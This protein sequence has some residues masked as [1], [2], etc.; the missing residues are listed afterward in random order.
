MATSSGHAKLNSAQPLR[1]APQGGAFSREQPQRGCLSALAACGGLSAK[2]TGGRPADAAVA[3]SRP[4]RRGWQNG[5][6]SNFNILAITVSAKILNWSA[7]RVPRQALLLFFPG[8]RGGPV[9]KKGYRAP[10]AARHRKSN[11]YITGGGSPGTH[12]ARCGQ[13]AGIP[14]RL[15]SLL[16]STE[17]FIDRTKRS[18][19]IWR[20]K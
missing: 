1:E 17:K 10:R 7:A 12:D 4:P 20:K 3:E 16:F 2:P 13:E 9:I 6:Q 11:W 15:F 8:R 18:A 14:S 5:F 19:I